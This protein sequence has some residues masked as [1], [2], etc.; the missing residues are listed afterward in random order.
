MPGLYNQMLPAGVRLASQ[1]PDMTMTF[2]YAKHPR[3][4]QVGQPTNN[5]GQ[6]AAASNTEAPGGMLEAVLR[7]E[8]R[9]ELIRANE[10]KIEEL[11]L[12]ISHAV[13]SDYCDELHSNY[14]AAVSATFATYEEGDGIIWVA[15]FDSEGNMISDDSD[16][17]GTFHESATEILATYGYDHVTQL[18]GQSINVMEFA[19]WDPNS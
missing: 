8:S 1:M 18:A 5:P 19:T 11:E 15:L 4:G 9:A 14:P 12:E 16:E 10:A 3:A 17:Y 6:F 2:D 13:V 7:A